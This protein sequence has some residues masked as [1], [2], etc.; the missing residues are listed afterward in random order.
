MSVKGQFEAVAHKQSWG[1]ELLFYCMH[2]GML[3]VLGQGQ[4]SRFTYIE[5]E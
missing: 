4:E 1:D 2:V 5:L 3:H